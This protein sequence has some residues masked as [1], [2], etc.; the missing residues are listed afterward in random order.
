MP[1]SAGA[2]HVFPPGGVCETIERDVNP[3][4]NVTF[5]EPSDWVLGVQGAGPPQFVITIVSVAFEPAATF[6]LVGLGGLKA[7]E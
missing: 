3:A 6:G 7:A 5:A 2:F 1:A 4:G